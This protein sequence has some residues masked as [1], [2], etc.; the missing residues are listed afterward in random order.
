MRSDWIFI[1]KVQRL[2]AYSRDK[3]EDGH[4]GLEKEEERQDR[5][6]EKRC[7]GSSVAL[8][9]VLAFFL[10]DD[11][12]DVERDPACVSASRRRRDRRP[13]SLWRHKCKAVI[14]ALATATNHSSQRVTSAS[15]DRVCG[16][17]TGDRVR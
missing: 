5:R 15:T 9:R 3:N 12:M 8:C 7:F 14:V 10:T 1:W 13:R 4:D 6:P 17:S 16:T 11:M 2:D